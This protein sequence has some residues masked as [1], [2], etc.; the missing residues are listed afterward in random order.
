M[1]PDASQQTLTGTPSPRRSSR[2]V[3][4]WRKMVRTPT[5]D[6]IWIPLEASDRTR[7]ARRFG[8]KHKE[9]LGVKA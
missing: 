3:A 5:G 4:R 6:W 9:T 8:Q 7:A 2:D 1:E